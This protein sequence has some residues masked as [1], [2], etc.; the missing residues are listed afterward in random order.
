MKKMDDKSSQK[1]CS[2]LCL[3]PII[4]IFIGFLLGWIVH[5]TMPTNHGQPDELI[6][7]ASRLFVLM[8]SLFGW[9]AGLVAQ[10]KKIYCAGSHPADDVS[11]LKNYLCI[12]GAA[13]ILIV[14]AAFL[15]NGSMIPYFTMTASFL[16][17]FWGEVK[18]ETPLYGLFG[19]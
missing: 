18:Y 7:L 1:Y 5:Y 17:I 3:A 13:A 12:V 14:A 16:A 15:R 9:A 2:T 11:N 4:G 10:Q 8:F 6:D 19:E